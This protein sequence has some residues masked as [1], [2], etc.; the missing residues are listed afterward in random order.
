MIARFFG[1]YRWLSNF[2]LV[3]VVLDG[4]TYP[5]VENAYQAA[6]CLYE[7]DR[8]RFRTCAPGYAKKLGRK[9]V[10][11]DDWMDIRV[12]VMRALLAQK[13]TPDTELAKSL[14]DTGDREL[15]EGNTWGD[16]FW[17]VC[18]GQGENVLGK[19]LMEIRAEL[20]VRDE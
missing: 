2:W 11:R 4:I 13:F 7:E 14:L 20:R 5:S 18:Y 6:K 1:Q 8:E 12:T 17:G 16:R 9:I 15:V 19:L 10:I 3:D